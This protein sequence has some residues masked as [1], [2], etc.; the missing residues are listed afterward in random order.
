V[1]V[2]LMPVERTPR[3]SCTSIA[4]GILQLWAVHRASIPAGERHDGPPDFDAAG[5]LP[6]TCYGVAQWEIRDLQE[7]GERAVEF[8]DQENRS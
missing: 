2:Q 7:S 8:Q 1:I 3:L 4:A 5:S 6:Y